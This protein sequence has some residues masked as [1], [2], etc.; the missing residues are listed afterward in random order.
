MEEIGVA[1]EDGTVP[2]VILQLQ[3]IN[4]LEKATDV[5]TFLSIIDKAAEKGL[6]LGATGLE[7]MSAEIK[8]TAQ[9]MAQS[10]EFRQQAAQQKGGQGEEV[11]DISDEE[12]LTAA[13]KVVFVNAKKNFDE[14]LTTGKPLLLQ[15]AMAALQEKEPTEAIANAL[16]T[17]PGGKELLQDVQKAKEDLQAAA[18]STVEGE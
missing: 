5:D 3:V 8:Q 1:A 14:Q 18:A 12:A 17:T 15:K 11:P 13:E 6:D 4:S 10:E 2:P 7:A 9:K 16:M